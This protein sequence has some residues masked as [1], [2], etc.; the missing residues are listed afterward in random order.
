MTAVLTTPASAQVPQE[1]LVRTRFARTI[2]TGDRYFSENAE[3][4]ARCAAEM[5]DHF[6]DGARLLVFGGGSSTTDAQHNSVE[7]VHPALPGCRALPAYSLTN[8]GA[9]VT[10]I[11]L[12]DDPGSVYEHQIQV[13]GRP[14]DIAL[15]FADSPPLPAIS[16][17]LDEA[18]D[19]GLLTVAMLVGAHDP[20]R[21]ADHQ[22][23]TVSDDHMVAQE[24]HL[25]TYH[26]L[27]ELVHIAL[28]H[29]GI[30]QGGAR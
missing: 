15:A 18:Q 16:R 26:M 5:A 24:L 4:I 27:W 28:N 13:F 9:T 2:D 10:G 1:E 7:F 20:G 21:L 30:P 22:F 23:R 11:L 25:A 6:W 19:R 17:G 29:R 8:D 3:A 12:G 14:G